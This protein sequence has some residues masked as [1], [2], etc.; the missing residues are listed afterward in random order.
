MRLGVRERSSDGRIV[1]GDVEVATARS[2][3]RPRAARR[4]LAVPGFVDLQVN[5]Y[6]GVDLQTADEAG[7]ERLSPRSPRPARP[8]GGRR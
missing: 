6:A 4:G 2:P 1:P 3:R 7:R 8:P 5:G